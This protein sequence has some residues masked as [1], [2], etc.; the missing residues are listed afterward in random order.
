MGEAKTNP[1][2]ETGQETTAA[3]RRHEH[4]RTVQVEIVQCRA[5]GAGKAS[6]LDVMTLAGRKKATLRRGAFEKIYRASAIDKIEIIKC[7]VAPGTIGDIADAMGAA[8]ATLIRNLGIPK[9]TLARKK[10][11]QAPLERDASEKVLGLATLIGQVETLVREQGE[12]KGFDAAR[13][14]HA[15]IEEPVP[16]LGGRKP[17]ELLDTKEGQQ[18]VSGLIDAI[19]AGVYL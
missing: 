12:P 4:A 8:T 7:G 10:S 17:A 19:R 6:G 15:W 13:W 5:K 18:I 9:S 1:T 14:F 3:R 16:A 11:K 2:R